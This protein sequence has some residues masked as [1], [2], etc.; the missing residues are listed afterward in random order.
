MHNG[1]FPL[2]TGATRLA[3]WFG[4]PRTPMLITFLFCAALFSQI[5]LWSVALFFFLWFVEFCLAKHDDRIFRIL[6]LFIKTKVLNS[7]N[8]PFFKKWGGSSYSPTDYGA[9]D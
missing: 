8:S 1:R 5:H 2:F 6:W 4:V 9:K 7:I 3:T